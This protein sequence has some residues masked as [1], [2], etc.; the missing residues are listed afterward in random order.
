MSLLSRITTLFRGEPR[1]VYE[2]PM[3][4]AG[5]TEEDTV[6]IL[7]VNSDGTLSGGGGDASASNQLAAIA[8]IEG[9]H[10]Q[11]FGAHGAKVVTDTNEATGPFYALT[12]LDDSVVASATSSNVSGNLT[13]LP[14]PAGTT[15]YGTFTAFTL[16][17]GKVIAY[18]NA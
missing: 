18:L 7:K 1:Q 17:S 8:A 15:I 12:A 13:D 14:L 9:F 11:A 4:V 3:V 5:R 2:W 16:T 6:V 10:G